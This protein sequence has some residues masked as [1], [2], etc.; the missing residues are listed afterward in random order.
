MVILDFERIGETLGFNAAIDNMANEANAVIARK[1]KA[2]AEFQ[3]SLTVEEMHAAALR[4]QVD[5]LL[6]ALQEVDPKNSLLERTG[7]VYFDGR[8]EMRI[9]LV[10]SNTFDAEGAKRNVLNPERFRK[11]LK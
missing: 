6:K 1:N 4:A 11:R 5:A 2:I 9:S 8:P 3:S 10:Y 7:R